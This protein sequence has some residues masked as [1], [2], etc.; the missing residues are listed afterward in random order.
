MSQQ[1]QS[2]ACPQCDGHLQESDD[3]GEYECQKCGRRLRES[4]VSRLESFKRVAE[5]D[6]PLAEIAEVALEGQQ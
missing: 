6:G 5:S 1:R 2:H 3:P 4:V